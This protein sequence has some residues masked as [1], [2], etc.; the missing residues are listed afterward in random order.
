[1]PNGQIL[2]GNGLKPDIEIKNKED[3]S[4]KDLQLEKALEFIKKEIRK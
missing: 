1:L 3:D 4:T 2:E